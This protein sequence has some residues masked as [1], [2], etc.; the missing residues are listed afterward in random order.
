MTET[1]DYIVNHMDDLLTIASLAINA[2]LA[3]AALT[4][5][6]T[7]DAVA[8]RLRNL[9]DAAKAFRLFRK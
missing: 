4:P 1:F 9:V 6:Q 7:D 3:V 5:T 8:G 2:A